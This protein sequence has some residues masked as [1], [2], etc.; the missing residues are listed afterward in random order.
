MPHCEIPKGLISA[1]QEGQCVAFVG[2]GFSA[3]A[4]LPPWGKL[5]E[6]IAATEGVPDDVRAHAATKIK[7]GSGHALD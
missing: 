3:A 4:N 5:L 2:A 6:L 7:E 1:I